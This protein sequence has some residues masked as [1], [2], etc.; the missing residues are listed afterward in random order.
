MRET[1]EKEKEKEHLPEITLLLIREVGRHGEQDRVVSLDNY[2][3]IESRKKLYV[4]AIGKY[5]QSNV[6]YC[7]VISAKLT[8]SV[9]FMD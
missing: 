5:G 9:E 6:R 8:Q 1:K 2:A 7:K 4:D 3:D